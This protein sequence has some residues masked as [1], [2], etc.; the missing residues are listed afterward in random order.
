M[1]AHAAPVHAH[2]APA[3]VAT[4]LVLSG[5]LAVDTSA[6]TTSTNPDGSSTTTVPVAGE[7]ATVG[8]VH[9]L[10]SESVD[11]YGDYMG[12][13]TL[14]LHTPNGAFVVVFNN[15]SP[16]PAHRAANGAVYYE[17]PQRLFDGVGAYAGASE[18]GTIELFTNHARSSIV[19]LTLNSQNT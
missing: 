13:D 2:G 19:S 9:G 11:A 5:T 16:G 6:A 15:S 1:H 8:E 12:P 14:G 4:P 18:S 17:H 7:L 10:W 3:V